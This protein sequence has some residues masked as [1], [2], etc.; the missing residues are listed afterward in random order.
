M[1]RYST[2]I[3]LAILFT[4]DLHSHPRMKFWPGRS[5]AYRQTTLMETGLGDL[6]TD[7]FRFAVRQAEGKNYRYVHIAVTA[8]GQIRDTFLTGGIV[9][10]DIFKVLSLGLGL[11]DRAG[12][13]LL[14]IYMTGKEI[15]SMLEVQTSIAPIK[16]DAQLQVSG[17]RFTFNPHRI[18]FD[19]VVSVAVQDEDGVFP[20]VADLGEKFKGSGGLPDPLNLLVSPVGIEPT[21]Y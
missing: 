2:L 20:C 3:G 4:H 7:T 18:P 5:P 10:A 16:H 1:R 21:T 13:P 17:V 14:T 6:V 8:D 12:Y 19:R 15:K 9:V 11:D